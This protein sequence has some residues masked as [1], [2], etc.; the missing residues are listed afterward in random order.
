[1]ILFWLY[2]VVIEY[3]GINVVMENFLFVCCLLMK[4]IFIVY[5]C[6]LVID[7]IDWCF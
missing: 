1:M 6:D 7:Y 3:F 4:F 2:Y 5:V